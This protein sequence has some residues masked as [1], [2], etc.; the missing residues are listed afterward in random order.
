MSFQIHST[1]RETSIVK[2]PPI[3]YRHVI[4][5]IVA[6]LLC[7]AT[8]TPAVRAQLVLL[9]DEST[10]RQIVRETMLDFAIAV[11][12]GD[13]S[14]FHSRMS[15]QLKKEITAEELT[16]SFRSFVDQ[17]IDLTR[18]ETEEPAFSQPPFLDSDGWLV[19]EGAYE[20]YPHATEFSLRY[21]H[22]S[23]SW[24]LVGIDLQVEPIPGSQPEP[25][26]LPTES[27][28]LRLVEDS[29]LGFANAVNAR[30]FTE[31]HSE[32]AVGFQRQFSPA[33]FATAFRQFSDQGID[34]TVLGG[35]QP[36]L[37][38]SPFINEDGLLVVSGRYV[39][40]PYS[41][42]FELEYMF[43]DPKWRLFG[44]DLNAMPLPDSTTDTKVALA[45]TNF[46]ELVNQSMMEFAIAVKAE[47]FSAFY[48]GISRMWQEQIA[49]E[50]LAEIFRGFIENEI[51]LTPVGNLKPSFITEPFVDENGVLRLEGTY[52]T[53]PSLVYFKLSFV[54]EGADWRLIGINVQIE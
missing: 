13:F 48:A 50:E 53:Q 54:L 6:A 7:S 24:K 40:A 43:E 38:E 41:V 3:A 49:E 5:A 10:I 37:S 12:A 34:L 1:M 28:V 26:E 46:E 4:G 27:E 25:G 17:S 9:P 18:V 23:Q 21:V 45:D 19:V 2:R 14:L 44:I 8:S 15:Q 20:I 11:K 36:E 29:V 22:E 42:P 35:H 47:D 31:F 32:C 30:D 51:D 52:P 16:A 33:Q 39:V